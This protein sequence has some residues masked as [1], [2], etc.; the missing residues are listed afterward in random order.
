VAVTY[1][2]TPGYPINL[3]DILYTCILNGDATIQHYGPT[4]TVQAPYLEMY[5]IN[6]NGNFHQK[7]F[8]DQW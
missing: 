4:P 1:N 2:M 7:W 6:S 8:T 3:N 5:C